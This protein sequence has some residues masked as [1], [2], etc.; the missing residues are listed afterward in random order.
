MHLVFDQ[1]KRS[2]LWML[3]APCQVNAKNLPPRCYGAV[4]ARD[5]ADDRVEG[6]H[7]Q[8]LQVGVG[9]S[10]RATAPLLVSKTGRVVDV[11]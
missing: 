1:E 4:R 2:N 7:L 5:D 11:D 6:E 9:G 3:P 8:Y 10:E